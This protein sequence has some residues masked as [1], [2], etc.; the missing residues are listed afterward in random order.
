[1]ESRT[2]TVVMNCNVDMFLNSRCYG[3]F[4]DPWSPE[5]KYDRLSPTN[6]GKK[7]RGGGVFKAQKRR[8]LTCFGRAQ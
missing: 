1:M 7:K 2:H 3:C 5:M 4:T 6:L 8:E